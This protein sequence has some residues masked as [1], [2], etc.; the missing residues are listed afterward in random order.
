VQLARRNAGDPAA[1]ERAA[2][3]ME[4]QVE[5]L[6]RLVDDLLDAS[7]VTRGKVALRK[8][9]V[10]LGA[11][12][13]TCAED[14]LGGATAAGVRLHAD[15]DAGL[16]VDGDPARLLQIVG[17]LLHNAV[18]FTPKGGEIALGAHA[19]DGR[20]RVTV[21]DSG[22]GIPQDLLPRLFQPFAQGVGGDPKRSGLGIG[23]AL[24]RGLAELHGGTAR[25]AS[26]GPGHGAEFTV[27][28]PLAQGGG[29]GQDAAPG[30]RKVLL[31]DDNDDAAETLAELLRLDGYDVVV[32][33]TG[34]QAVDLAPRVRPDV[35]I[36]DIGLPPPMDGYAVARALRAS[37]EV[38]GAFLVA[39]TGYAGAD[40]RRR[41]QQ[42]GFDLHLAKPPS[43]DRL[44][45]VLAGK[46]A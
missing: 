46:R 43:L 3:I 21:R 27:E 36:C 15:V 4:R 14:A 26:P 30:A 32:A 44:R 39:L 31:V 23:L 16:W 17:N 11:L 38:R 25:A 10:E 13:K 41:A 19:V 40:D 29:P 9:R 45:D 24:V 35:V 7:R 20:A 34:P 6:T 33:G 42:A 1:V 18:K 37:P 8:E 22:A 12:V 2:A 28:L 5:Q